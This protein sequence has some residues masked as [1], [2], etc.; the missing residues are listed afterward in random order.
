M[1]RSK[2][3]GERRGG[4]GGEGHVCAVAAR[5]SGVTTPASPRDADA[6]VWPEAPGGS[7]SSRLLPAS[8][9]VRWT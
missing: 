6:D 9:E 5:V 8:A 7:L 2:H 1:V 4:S 3:E